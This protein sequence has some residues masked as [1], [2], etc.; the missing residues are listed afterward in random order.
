MNGNSRITRWD[1][2]LKILV[3]K[4]LFY[5]FPYCYKFK[6][7]FSL[8]KKGEI[9]VHKPLSLGF[10][11]FTRLM[12]GFQKACAFEEM[13]VGIP[14]CADLTTISYWYHKLPLILLWDHYPT[15]RSDYI[16]QQVKKSLY[17][18]KPHDLIKPNFLGNQAKVLSR[19]N[20]RN[21]FSI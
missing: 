15:L 4:L 10:F 19:R 18:E 16:C 14:K 8:R 9:K 12:L 2:V 6:E 21:V 17:L 7:G 3:E 11:F 1:F 5:H 20:C 13:L